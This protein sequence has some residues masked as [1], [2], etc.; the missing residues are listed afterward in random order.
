LD[1]VSF[2]KLPVAW[3]NNQVGVKSAGGQSVKVLNG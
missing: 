2:Q 1:V 3:A